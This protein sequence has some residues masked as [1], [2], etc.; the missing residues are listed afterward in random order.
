MLR[1][2]AFHFNSQTGELTTLPSCWNLV[3]SSLGNAEAEEILLETLNL[4]FSTSC[5]VI[6][7]TM[8]SA[9]KRASW[10][11]PKKV[12]HFVFFYS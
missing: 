3:Y 6:S 9:I 5:N 7:I 1:I 11:E 12:S 2:N 8:S 10:E 4:G